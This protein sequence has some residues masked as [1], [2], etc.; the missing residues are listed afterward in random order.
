M[1]KVSAG[2]LLTAFVKDKE[3]YNSYINV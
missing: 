1:L 2:E 3:L